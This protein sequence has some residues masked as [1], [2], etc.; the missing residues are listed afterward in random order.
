M[1]ER[2]KDPLERL[3]KEHIKVS[4]Y[5]EYL[6]KLFALLLEDKGWGDIQKA[7]KFFEENV[8]R[9]FDYEEK[10]FPILIAEDPSPETVT[11]CLEIVK[12]HGSILK[13][14]EDYRRLIQENPP[15][16]EKTNKQLNALGRTVRDHLLKHAKKEDEEL[17]PILEKNR[18]I[19]D[20]I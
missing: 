16:D 13:E 8:I 15:F 20:K 19:F 3:I 10:L 6:E 5:M 17:L 7:E 9:H 1:E 11:L 14:L 2:Y 18:Q 4:E 12:D